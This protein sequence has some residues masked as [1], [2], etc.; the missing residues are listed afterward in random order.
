M[1]K[2]IKIGFD[3]DGVILDHTNSKINLASAMGFEITPAQTPS[4]V[5][6]NHLPPE[7][8]ERIKLAIYKI[9]QIALTSELMSGAREVLGSLKE[10]GIDFYLI[11]RRKVPVVAEQT[12][13]KLGLWNEIFDETNTFFVEDI[14]Q[15]AAKAVELGITHFID[16]EKKVLDI[17]NTVSTK[18]LF[19][20]HQISESNHPKVSSWEELSRL[21]S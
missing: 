20:Q 4:D 15:K 13:V 18:I 17:M 16:D 9:P 6:E 3:F 2:N 12:L 19:D 8:V 5:F 14:E 10:R 7:V 21:F 1:L 11:S